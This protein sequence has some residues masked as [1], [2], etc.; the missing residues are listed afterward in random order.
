MSLLMPGYDS[1]M[2]I[3]KRI[4]GFDPTLVFELCVLLAACSTLYLYTKDFMY[5]IIH[6]YCMASAEI[7]GIDPVYAYLMRWMTIHQVTTGSRSIK[8]TAVP[9]NTEEDYQEPLPQSTS[10]KNT[11]PINYR[12]TVDTVPIRFLPSGRYT[13]WY[14]GNFFIFQHTTIPPSQRSQSE[15]VGTYYSITLSCFSRSLLPIRTLLHTAQRE[16][17]ASSSAGTRIFRPAS[18]GGGSQ[19]QWRLVVIR[20]ARALDTVILDAA[21]KKALLDDINEYLLPATRRWYAS[22]GIPYRRGYLFSGAPGTGKS[23]MTS[24]LAG[25]F[26]LHIYSI[27]LMD[28]DITESGLITLF[29]TLPRRC[30]TLLEDADAAGLKRDSATL[31]TRSSLPI[32]TRSSTTQSQP[33]SLSALLNVIDG[34]AS[35]EGRVLVLTSNF[36]EALDPALIRPGRVDMHVHFEL[37][38]KTEIRDLFRAMYRDVGDAGWSSSERV[39]SAEGSGDEEKRVDLDALG[40]AFAAKIPE[41]RL[42]LASVQGHLLRWKKEPQRAVEGVEDW[43]EEVLGGGAGWI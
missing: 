26:G 3:V 20:P 17:F 38:T 10:S 13:F 11:Q 37:A 39:T 5:S 43:C 29:T 41:G 35:H 14:E 19:L 27:S 16:F 33:I 36:P 4:T 42:S 2:G 15:F 18:A 34:V 7:D 40:E 9:L 21:K 22:H 25:V 8:A 1:A 6:N 31:S 24:A 28:P 30:I 32:S 23:S 12:V